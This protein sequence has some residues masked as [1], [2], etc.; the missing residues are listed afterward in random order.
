VKTQLRRSNPWL[1]IFPTVATVDGR[2][3][4]SAARKPGVFVSSGANSVTWEEMEGVFKLACRF[5]GF[6]P[7]S[8]ELSNFDGNFLWV[9]DAVDSFVSE[10]GMGETGKGRS[11]IEKMD[12]SSPFH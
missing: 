3:Y 4:A 6:T 8:S 5:P 9:S 12:K 1:R 2:T 10:C 7:D 11:S